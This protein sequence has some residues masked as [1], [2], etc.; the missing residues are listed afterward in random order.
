M[1]NDI[2]YVITHSTFLFS[3][4]FGRGDN[5]ILLDNVRCNGT[6]GSLSECSHNGW[7]ESNCIHLEDVS[8]ICLASPSKC[9]HVIIMMI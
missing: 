7:G 5:K 9:D 6:E 1:S 4:A 3:L 2:A 8:V